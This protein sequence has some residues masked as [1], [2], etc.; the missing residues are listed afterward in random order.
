MQ[1]KRELGRKKFKEESGQEDMG[2]VGFQGEDQPKIK[3]HTYIKK[4]CAAVGE[5]SHSWWRSEYK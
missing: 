5:E 1:M 4:Q 3:K 2:K